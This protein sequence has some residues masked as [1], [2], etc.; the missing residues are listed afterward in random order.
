MR[1]DGSLLISMMPATAKDLRDGR[2]N[3]MDEFRDDGMHG[4]LSAW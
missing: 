1:F 2:S 4:L 3:G